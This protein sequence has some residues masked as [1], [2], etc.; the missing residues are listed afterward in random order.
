MR[1]PGL[2]AFILLLLAGT[3]AAFA[4]T[5]RLKLERSPV[6][7]PRFDRFVSPAC[8][9]PAAAARL[10]FLL[11]RPERIDVAVVRGGGPVRALAV[12]VERPAGRVAFTWDGRDEARRIVPDGAYRVRVRLD[13]AR[14]TI[15]IP[16]EV[17]V[18]TRAP[19]ARLLDVSRTIVYPASEGRLSTVGFSYTANEFGTPRVEIDGNVAAQADGGRR[20][21]RSTL[22]WRAEADGRP[23]D[24]GAYAVSIRVEDRAGN[25]SAAAGPV[26]IEVRYAE[27]SRG[28]YR[29]RRG[30]ML[31]FA[32]DAATPVRWALLGR[33]RRERVIL[34]GAAEPGPVAVR[35]PQRL[36]ANAYILV[37]RSGGYEDRAAVRVLRRTQGRRLGGP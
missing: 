37:A 3:A 21:G 33:G 20:P 14:R 5:E 22:V 28:S 13:R 11:R 16:V 17:H 35:L 6:G 34:A 36:R 9:C 24:P 10:S 30:G 29:V 8:D 2:T 27:L 19:S 25:V 1:R 4:V 15:V 32:V 23:L 12:D 26:E 18:D 31:R 7:V